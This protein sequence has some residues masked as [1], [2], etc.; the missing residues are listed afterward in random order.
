MNNPTVAAITAKHPGT[1]LW[2]SDGDLVWQVET[3]PA[4]TIGE[5]AEAVAQA[6]AESWEGDT[7]TRGPMDISVEAQDADGC[8]IVSAFAE[9]TVGPPIPD[10]ELDRLHVWVSFPP[11]DEFGGIRAI[12]GGM[13]HYDV[14]THC[15][16]R[17]TRNTA[18]TKW[19]GTGE[20]VETVRH[21]HE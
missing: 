21:W 5:A 16:L 1:T 13:L 20:A 15:G 3:D 4:L 2:A 10:C 11:G 17:R 9:V 7:D 6:Y 14:C 18:D 8:E 12:R 19:T